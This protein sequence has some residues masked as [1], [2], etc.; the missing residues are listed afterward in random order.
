MDK[1]NF[2][3]IK[4]LCF[5]GHHQ[6]SKKDSFWNGRKYL[7]VVYKYFVSRAKNS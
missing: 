2:I 3:K 1:L 5:S 4:A 7:Q 6:E